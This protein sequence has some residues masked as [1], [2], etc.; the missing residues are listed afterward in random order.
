MNDILIQR[1]ASSLSRR[2]VLKTALASAGALSVPTLLHAQSA[3]AI[4][5]GFI[6]P[7]TGPYGADSQ[8]ELFGAQLAVKQFNDAGGL[9]GRKAELLARDCRLNAGEGATRALELIEADKVDF[10]AGPFGP[11]AFS[12]N[13]VIKSKGIPYTPIANSDSI[14]NAAEWSKYLFHEGLTPTATAGALARHVMSQGAKRIVMLTADYVYGQEMAAGFRTAAE[15]K[16][17][18]IVG[19]VKHSL[20]ATDYSTLF[21]RILALKP[22]LL[23]INNFGR[24]QQ[25]ALKQASE[26]GLK[27]K[28]KLAAPLMVHTARM[29][30]GHKAYEGVTGCIGYYWRLEDRLASAKAFNEGFR[31]LAGGGNPSDYAALGFASVISPL[32]AIKQA[33]STAPDAIVEAMS[34]MQLDYYKGPQH[35]RA[36]DHQSVQSVLIVES[37]DAAKGKSKD[38]VFRILAIEEGD[39]SRLKSCKDLGFAV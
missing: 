5:V 2:R 27:S 23:V 32:N 17:A 25:I 15:I 35:Y 31:A 36:C 16:G 19:E 39:D 37:Q 38:D 30:D 18:Q 6:A 9:N 26:F 11:S 20:G 12:I 33:N 24:D 7:M 4:K 34:K 8:L 1:H 21:P 3:K 13:G 29:V 28:M 10:I 22:D 14:N